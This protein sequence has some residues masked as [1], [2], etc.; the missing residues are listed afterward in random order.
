MLFSSSGIAQLIALLV[1]PILSRI[2][3]PEEHGVITT[4]VSLI[5]IGAAFSTLKYE[6]AIIV[7][8]DRDKARSLVVLSILIGL[9]STL[10][11]IIV[12][13]LG[14]PLILQ[15]FDLTEFSPWLLAIPISIFLASCIETLA[16]W[17]NRERKYKKLSTVRIASI[18][19]ASA[20]KLGHKSLNIIPMNGL[21]FGHVLGQIVNFILFIPKNFI[22]YLKIDFEVI[23]TLAIKYKSFPTWAMPAGLI[24][25]IGSNM[26]VFIIAYFLGSE[27]TGN[28]GNAIK[29]TFVPLAAVSYAFSQVYYER[30][31]RLS[32]SLERIKLSENILKFL[33]FIAI[34][35]V[36]VLTV[37]GDIITPFI[38]GDNWQ[39]SGEMVR[40]I[41]LFYLVMYISSPFSAAF[42]VYNKLKIQFVYTASFAVITSIAL[43]IS[44]YYTDNIYIAL[45]WF[46]GLGAII[47]LA[48]LAHCL[49]IIGRPSIVL[50]LK[51]TALTAIALI[52]LLTL[53][54]IVI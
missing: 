5:S 35:P 46:C 52:I 21:V 39:A 32:Q 25:V 36:L 30:L 44:L 31:A 23:K 7:E 10:L 24:N 13:I 47:R 1:V 51:A 42:E 40:I 45:L 37:W 20:Y 11:I 18:A 28:F 27:I 54:N 43:L 6:Q 17:W 38:L 53:R 19:S 8:E 49:L 26:P 34:I 50:I 29:L 4:F 9:M 14:K 16:V 12:L 2:F 15:L 48:M 33:Y 41:A 3:S 22:K